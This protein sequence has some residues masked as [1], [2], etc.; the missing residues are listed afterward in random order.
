M[1]RFT[2]LTKIEKVADIELE[3]SALQHVTQTM[4]MLSH[5]WLYYTK[6]CR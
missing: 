5:K 1:T 3:Y 2:E 6:H 4:F